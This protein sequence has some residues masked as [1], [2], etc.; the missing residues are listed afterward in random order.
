MTP[1]V[2]NSSASRREQIPYKKEYDKEK[3]DEN[4]YEK[5]CEVCEKDEKKDDNKKECKPNSY[6]KPYCR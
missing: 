2:M 3:Y 6:Q 4:L 5:K 1:A